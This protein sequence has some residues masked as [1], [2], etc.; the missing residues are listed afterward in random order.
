MAVVGLIFLK[1]NFMR[2]VQLVIDGLKKST[3]DGTLNEIQTHLLKVAY[4]N[5]K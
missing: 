5:K 4:K 3:D 2:I 1:M